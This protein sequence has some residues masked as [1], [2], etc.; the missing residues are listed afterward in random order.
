MALCYEKFKQMDPY[1]QERELGFWL[2]MADSPQERDQVRAQ[3]G[4]PQEE[5]TSQSQSTPAPPPPPAKK[6]KAAKK[7]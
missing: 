7:G 3:V 2:M 6:E 5:T 4:Y 1:E